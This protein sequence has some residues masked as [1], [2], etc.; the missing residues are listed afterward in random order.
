[1]S[2]NE[3]NYFG[4]H[5]YIEGLSEEEQHPE[6]LDRESL[7]LHDCY[8]REDVPRG[9]WIEVDLKAIEHNIRVV[10]NKVG[11][12]RKILAVVKADG[13]GHGAVHVAQAALRA[14]VDCL[15]VSSVEE[16]V[17]LREADIKAPILILSQPPKRAI[18]YLLAYDLMP[19]VFTEDFA[20][21]LGEEADKNGMVA[22]YH[23]AIDTGMNR[24]GIFYLDVVD[25]LQSINFHRGIELD[26]VFTHFATADEVSDW[27]FRMQLQRFNEALQLMRNARID[28]G[29]VHSANSAATMRY[30]EAHFDMVRVGITMYGLTPSP[31][32]RDKD[33]LVPAMA[34][35]AQITQVREP[36]MGEGVS[37]GFNYRVAKPVQIATVPIGYADGVQ[38]ALSGRMRVLYR[39]LPCRQV[40]N[41]CMDQMMIEIP[42]EYATEELGGPAEIGEEV[43]ILGS[44]GD[45]E[46]TAD[47]MADELDTI[48]YELICVFGLRLPRIYVE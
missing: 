9:A 41:I 26:G 3:S 43:V 1:M 40:G 31:V 22:K 37:Y 42:L 2:L 25:F 27:D 14:G 16:G 8:T 34:I 23:L 48:S 15:G 24:I 11:L 28:Y 33:D 38:R 13:Y 20:L 19:T 46:I 18:P 6:H 12:N 30:P 5:P 32:L 17:E 45:Y 29:T 39:G 36:Q 47:M 10:R 21:A 4:A 44:Q 35:K 7:K